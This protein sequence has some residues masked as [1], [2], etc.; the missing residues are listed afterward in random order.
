MNKKLSEINLLGIN[1]TNQSLSNILES[2]TKGLA[3]KG[4]KFYIVTPN[5]EILVYASG[6]PMFKKIMNEAKLALPDGVG[7][8]WA[9]KI[10]GKPLQYRITG[11]D[12]MESLCEK[13][14]E[15]PV[16]VGF[17]GGRKG[18]AD[19][20]AKCL[21]KKYPGLQISYVGEEW[22]EGKIKDPWSEG[23]DRKRSKIKET[24]EMAKDQRLKTNGHIDILFVAYGFPKQEE[25]IAE[26]LEQLPFTAAMGV[27]GAFDYIS[28][29]VSRA[30]A[31]VRRLGFEWL[32][33][34]VRQPWRIKRQ[35]KLVEFMWLV[36]KAKYE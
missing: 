22:E 20:T 3:L 25:W 27:G 31:W 4:D 7:L 30:P 18:V 35:L 28:G 29:R 2:V 23:Q 32:W 14:A 1:I 33:R 13:V 11:V 26:N 9:S 36:F 6:H 8:I 15:E 5:P 10:L 21:L 24:N 12:F 19:E 17:L 34:L 16:T